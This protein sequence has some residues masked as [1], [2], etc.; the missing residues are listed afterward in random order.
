MLILW[1]EILSYLFNTRSMLHTAL[2]SLEEKR[3]MS[4]AYARW[5]TIGQPLVVRYLLK[6]NLKPNKFKLRLKTSAMTMKIVANRDL[7]VGCYRKI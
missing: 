3:R 5:V 4:S 1:P 6:L 7:L 2:L